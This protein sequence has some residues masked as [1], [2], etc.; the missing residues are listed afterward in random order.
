MKK[1][2]LATVLSLCV[3]S[4]FAAD[5]SAVLKLKG[6]LT[7]ASCTPTLSGGGTIDYGTVNLGSLSA[8]A[9]N[10]LGQKDFSLTITCQAPVKV[11]FSVNDDRSGT[12]A[13]V[14]VKNGT[15]AGVDVLQPVNLFGVNTTAGNV[16]IGNYSMFVKTDSVTADG[17]AVGATYSSDNGSSWSNVGSLMQNNASEIVTVATTGETAPLAFTQAVVPMAISLAIQDTTT[18]AITDDTSIDGQATFTLKYL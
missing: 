16:K 15:V 13:N 8:T 5:P 11:G 7:N 6:T 9:V 2:W 1:V 10:Q 3:S 4:A 18:L 12:A 17:K 14:V